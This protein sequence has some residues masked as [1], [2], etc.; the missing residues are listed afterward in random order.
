MKLLY[1]GVPYE[2]NNQSTQ[3]PL[4]TE[5]IEATTQPTVQLRYRGNTYNYQPQPK[6]V[7]EADLADAPMVTLMY[8]G[9]TYQRKLSTPR[10]YQAPRALNW[11]WQFGS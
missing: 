9:Q 6:L 5:T 8:R 11:R 10:T 2:T 7:P 1:R 4:A 3:S